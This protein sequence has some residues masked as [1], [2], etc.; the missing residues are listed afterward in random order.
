[1]VGGASEQL[2]VLC[3]QPALSSHAQEAH[4]IFDSAVEVVL[5]EPLL[6]TVAVE[7]DKH[8][9]VEDLDK[10]AATV[11][12]GEGAVDG[13]FCDGGSRKA[14]E[15]LRDLLL[16]AGCKAITNGGCIVRAARWPTNSCFTPARTS[17]CSRGSG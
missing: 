2:Y 6:E 5:A 13:G 9:A 4:E 11:V 12:L 7:L 14:R 8:L 15:E 10:L 17:G 3:Q 16:H 1:M